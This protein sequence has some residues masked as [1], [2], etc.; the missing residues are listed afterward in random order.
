MSGLLFRAARRY[1]VVRRL[2]GTVW[3][4]PTNRSLSRALISGR[5]RC[6]STR[7]S[8]D[9]AEQTKSP[10]FLEAKP[11]RSRHG[12][13][14]FCFCGEHQPEYAVWSADSA[15][16]MRLVGRIWFPGED[17]KRSFDSM[18]MIVFSFINPPALGPT[19]NETL[20]VVFLSIF[21]R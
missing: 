14:S 5:Y 11:T 17:Q 12:L 6:V 8:R 1:Q 3:K 19:I 15:G 2:N 18:I 16:G 21:L 9:C 7:S 4:Q 13:Y 20:Y 10:I